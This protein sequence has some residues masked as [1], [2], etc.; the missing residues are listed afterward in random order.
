MSPN[1]SRQAEVP[2][3]MIHGIGRYIPSVRNGFRR[4]VSMPDPVD[5][6]SAKFFT[7]NSSD[8]SGGAASS[9]ALGKIRLIAWSWD[10]RKRADLVAKLA[11]K[12]VQDPALLLEI[13]PDPD[14]GISIP[15]SLLRRHPDHLKLHVAWLASWNPEWAE[16]GDRDLVER[17]YTLLRG[18]NPE[19]AFTAV[20]H[21]ATLDPARSARMLDDLVVALTKDGMREGAKFQ[22]G[23]HWLERLSSG[24]N[25]R[26]G[27][28]HSMITP[29][30]A[31]LG[32]ALVQAL[33][34]Q[35]RGDTDSGIQWMGEASRLFQILVT[36]RL[37]PSAVETAGMIERFAA[38]S[39]KPMIRHMQEMRDDLGLPVDLMG[40]P[41]EIPEIRVDDGNA[42]EPEDAASMTDGLRSQLNALASP[43]LKICLLQRMGQDALA[44]Q[45]LAEW[46]GRSD[47][48][49][50][51]EIIA[52]W[53]HMQRGDWMAADAALARAV[54][55]RSFPKDSL[56]D[57]RLKR[58][59]LRFRASKLAE[60]S[61]LEILN[62][63][64]AGKHS[65]SVSYQ[66]ADLLSRAGLESAA[67]EWRKDAEDLG[68]KQRADFEKALRKQKSHAPAKPRIEDESGNTESPPPTPEQQCASLEKQ[69][70]SD[71]GKF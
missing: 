28:D 53:C 71:P 27:Q 55:K 31:K 8:P 59:F 66:I 34:S 21:M 3:R 29:I 67:K 52:A 44:R 56:Q 30:A 15:G 50:Q 57:I 36:M 19:M 58:I 61:T 42:G 40:L 20:S 23:F 65:S 49:Y 5:R 38:K 63:L 2:T 10:E 9:A 26:N 48:D 11:A 39:P 33:K 51:P 17:C 47:Q 32:D 45:A 60:A 35:E 14:H 64:R 6:T 7:W 41:V 12:G 16:P 69:L 22:M 68:E 1:S 18:D 13:P 46:Q 43:A 25:W 24:M 37:W 54:D 70:A 62:K 4:S